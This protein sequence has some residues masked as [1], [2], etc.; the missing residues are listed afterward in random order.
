MRTRE[1]QNITRTGKL[2]RDIYKKESIY[3]KEGI[4][5]RDGITLREG[6]YLRRN[7]S[8]G[9]LSRRSNYEKE[10]TTLSFWEAC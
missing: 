3:E 2:S 10:S 7:P 8:T 1:R 9:N 4:N 5:L 6:I